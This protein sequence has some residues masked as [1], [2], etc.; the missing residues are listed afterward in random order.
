M[1]PC[2]SAGVRRVVGVKRQK[3]SVTIDR[4]PS[5]VG[6]SY[7]LAS[8]VDQLE[9]IELVFGSEAVCGVFHAVFY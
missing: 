4:L 1:T 8:L 9:R 3:F 5:L 6:A 7:C 2:M